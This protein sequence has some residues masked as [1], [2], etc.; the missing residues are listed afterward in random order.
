MKTIDQL[1]EVYKECVKG[2]V[3]LI[4]IFEYRII[5]RSSSIHVTE[6]KS[7][8]VASMLVGVGSRSYRKSCH[9]G[10][11]TVLAKMKR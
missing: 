9:F 2:Y 6:Y 5:V 3:Y 8:K 4:I 11:K 10:G 7:I 1:Y